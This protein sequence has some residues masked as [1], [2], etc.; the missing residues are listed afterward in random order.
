[1]EHTDIVN[2]V[3]EKLGH[4][5]LISELTTRLSHSDVSTLLLALYKEITEQ[6]SASGL[7]GKYATNR[8]VKPAAWSPIRLKRI[9]LAMLE[10]A[11]CHGFGPIEL[12]PASIL[13]SCSVV[14]K[15]AQNKVVSAARGVELIS[16]S[17]NML[18]I[19]LANGINNKTIDNAASDVQVCSACRVTRAQ[20][21]EGNLAIPH[22]G[23]FSLVSSGK[24]TGSYR[25]EKEAMA[26]QI[27][28]YIHYYGDRLGKEVKVFLHMRK[29]YTDSDGFMDRMYEH[30]I[31][32]FPSCSFIRDREAS[33][34]AYYRG[35][36][37][38]IDVNG[39]SI[40]DG[41]FVDWT[42]QLLGNKKERLLI[43]GT[44]IDLQLITGLVE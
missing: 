9:E 37:F 18:A 15:V 29:G 14:A 21:F 38:K 6:S 28:Y 5:S 3:L 2:R 35:I 13:G 24:D 25:F 7:L 17:T 11:E 39:A 10:S 33:D 20:Q 27:E 36:N 41:G 42:Q 40:V 26:K 19:Y 1:M 44:G 32:R 30:L 23:L 4:E 31:G 22:F 16:D 43:S 34:N 8:F 12:S